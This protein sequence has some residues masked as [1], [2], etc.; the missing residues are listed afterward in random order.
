MKKT[1]Q[2][3]SILIK[4]LVLVAIVGAGIIIYQSCAGAPLIQK[5]DKSMPSVTEAPLRVATQTKTYL[6]ERAIL[7]PG[8]AVT[9]FN[10]YEKDGE[11]WVFHKGR[12]TLPS[13]WRPR[14][15]K[16]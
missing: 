11:E 14:I 9:M 1:G 15:S 2:I 16:R 4:I 3:L 6:A 8:R 7:T 13:G 10:W 5:I 12:I